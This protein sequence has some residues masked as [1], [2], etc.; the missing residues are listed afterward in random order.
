LRSIHSSRCPVWNSGG[1]LRTLTVVSIVFIFI[2]AAWSRAR[3]CE[4]EYLLRDHSNL[5]IKSFYYYLDGW[6]S[7]DILAGAQTLQHGNE[8]LIKLRGNGPSQFEAVLSGEKRVSR[9]VNDLC[10]PARQITVFQSGGH[11]WMHVQ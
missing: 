7:P 1:A 2:C 4:A 9:Q 5:E 8:Q 11:F 10:G 6:K 3:G